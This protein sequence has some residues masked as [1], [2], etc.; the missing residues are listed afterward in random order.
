MRHLAWICILAAGFGGLTASAQDTRRRTDHHAIT[1][2]SK[3]VT[4]SFVMSGKVAEVAVKD[5]QTVTPKQVVVKLDDKLERIRLQKLKAEAENDTRIKAAAAQLAQKNV[6]LERME[7]LGRKN[8]A[9]KWE[10]EQARLEKIIGELSLD[11]AKFEHAQAAVDY[12]E[13]RKGL[14]RMKLESPI[15]GVVEGIE[16]EVGEAVDRLEPAV[17]IV[18]LD[19]LWIDVPVPLADAAKLQPDQAATVTLQDRS[20]L[21]G[22]VIHKAAVADA[23]SGTLI[24]R[25]EVPNPQQRP[26]GEHV[27]VTFGPGTAAA[28][29]DTTGTV[30]STRRDETDLDLSE[31]TQTPEDSKGA[32]THGRSQHPREQ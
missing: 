20:V 25:V 6:D 28:T 19:P 3:V 2:P 12:A 9:T 26:A 11:L 21:K 8:V 32:P 4:L 27:T 10:I 7:D 24:V 15:A 30:A 17:K 16:V 22:K 13:A 18:K 23:A 29:D 1:R 5:G 14:D 31:Q